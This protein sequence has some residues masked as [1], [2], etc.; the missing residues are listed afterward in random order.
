MKLNAYLN[1]DGACRE[2]FQFY[3]KIFGGQIAAMMPMGEGPMA[4]QIPKESH[5]RIMHARL[6]VDDQVLMGSDCVNGQAEKPAGIAVAINVDDPA[7]ADRIFNALAVNGNVRM[8]IA[9]TFWALRFGDLV[10]QF[11]IPWL[12][13]CEKPMQGK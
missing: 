2:A 3:N 9:E 10:D 5:D 7:E 12:V 1:F 4:E 13:N 8:P 6:I 11:G